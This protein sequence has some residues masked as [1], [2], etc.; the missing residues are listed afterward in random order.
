M[1]GKVK[2]S[3]ETAVAAALECFR[4]FGYEGAS[5]NLLSEATG[6]GRSSL[7]HYFPEGKEE[8]ALAAAELVEQRFNELVIGPLQGPE[9]PM[10]RLGKAISGL[11]QF[12][13][14]G[15]DACLIDIFS[16]G[17]TATALPGRVKGI[18][19]AVIEAF[20]KLSADANKRAATNPRASAVRAI[21]ELEGA[22][23]LTRATGDRTIFADTLS[24]LPY[25]LSVS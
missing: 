16:I 25:I 18:A 20:E 22:L 4:R 14:G 9:P 6:L 15:R 11:D 8:I 5:L 12:Y 23:V 17:D 7:Y 3:R 24:R 2:S 10:V 19:F 1:R 13:N 21:V